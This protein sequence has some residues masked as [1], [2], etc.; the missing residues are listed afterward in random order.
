M[1]IHDKDRGGSGEKRGKLSNEPNKN[2]IPNVLSNNQ[3]TRQVASKRVQRGRRRVV[4][5]Q[6]PSPH[7]PAGVCR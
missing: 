7:S 4:P 6:L 1:A 2:N 5:S 3:G